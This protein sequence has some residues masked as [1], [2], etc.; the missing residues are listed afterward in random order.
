MQLTFKILCLVLF[1]GA[2]TVQGITSSARSEDARIQQASTLP[3][4]KPLVDHHAHLISP[5]TADLIN[6]PPLPAIDVPGPIADL[7]TRRAQLWSDPVALARLFTPDALVLIQEEPKSG[8]FRGN[9]VAAQFLS[10]RFARGYQLTPA[11]F[12]SSGELAHVSGYYTRGATPDVSRIG[13]FQL[14]LTKATGEKWQ[15][16]SEAPT[17]PAQPPQRPVT[18]DDLIAALDEAGI[19]KAIVLSGAIVIGGRW[20]DIYHGT[21]TAAE[22]QRMVR[23]ENDWTAAQA[24]R[25]PNRLISFCSL[26]PLEPYALDELRRCAGSRHRG[27]KLHFDE[28]GLDLT[29]PAHVSKAHSIF[30]AANELRLPIVVHVGNNDGSEAARLATV[31]LDQ[32]AAAAPDI[33]IQIAHLWGGSGYSEGALHAFADAVRSNRAGTRNLW[34]DMAE[35]PLIAAQTEDTK[36]QVLTDVAA[37][38]RQI[39]VDRVLFGSDTGGKGHLTPAKAW[40]QFRSDVPLRTEEFEAIARNVAPYAR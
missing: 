23:H 13:Q 2:S 30:K 36:A 6:G 21:S 19:S 1:F 5:V 33:T 29:Q 9:E 32:V 3:E 27:L 22:R 34:F 12:V 8:F 10:R 17:F 25:Y 37:R 28:A 11:E 18:A 39:G 35:A 31:F 20:L 16:S 40:A 14:L 4:A 24:A 38:I 15:I 7:L 26:N